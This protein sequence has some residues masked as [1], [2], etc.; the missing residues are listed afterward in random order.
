MIGVSKIYEDK[1]LARIAGPALLCLVALLFVWPT[2]LFSQAGRHVKVLLESQQLGN[3]DR[4]SVCGG[5]SVIIWRGSVT[6][7]GRVGAAERQTTVQRST[8]I[9]TLVRDGGESIPT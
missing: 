4:S 8:G 3:L 6:P 7:A 1:K 9:F 5:G 2:E